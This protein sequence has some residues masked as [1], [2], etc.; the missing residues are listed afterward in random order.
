M[1][2]A[3]PQRFLSVQSA[4]YNTCYTQRRLV[5]TSTLRRFRADARAAWNAAVA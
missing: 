1:S 4:I 2:K 5:S 3:S